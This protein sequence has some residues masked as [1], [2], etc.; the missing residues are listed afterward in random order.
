MLFED[1]LLKLSKGIG[2]HNRDNIQWCTHDGRP[3][4]STT[5]KSL[6]FLS[7]ITSG[8][9]KV[10]AEDLAFRD[11]DYFIAGEIHQD[12]NGVWQQILHGYHKQEEILKHISKVFL[13]SISSIISKANSKEMVTTRLFH[14]EC[15]S[16]TTRSATI[17]KTLSPPH[18]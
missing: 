3:S 5:Q 6:S 18:F 13:C 15:F 1:R 2:I 12:Y 11:T 17:F 16:K 8:A 10:S 7:S 4:S 14:R 9:I